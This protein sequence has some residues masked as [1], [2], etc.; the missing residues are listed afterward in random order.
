MGREKKAKKTSLLNW[1]CTEAT[2]GGKPLAALR[3]AKEI[4]NFSNSKNLN[5]CQ[6]LYQIY[7]INIQKNGA[8]KIVQD[9]K[10]SFFW[11]EYAK[12]ARVCVCV[13]VCICAMVGVV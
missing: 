2:T 3:F 4:R 12:C 9:R 6:P 13:W 10:T 8:Q 1:Y 11:A 7:V 5:K